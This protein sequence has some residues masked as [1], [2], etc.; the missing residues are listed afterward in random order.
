MKLE[1]VRLGAHGGQRRHTEEERKPAEILR[2]W[3]AV[4]SSQAV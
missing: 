1:V 4:P 2:S 3:F